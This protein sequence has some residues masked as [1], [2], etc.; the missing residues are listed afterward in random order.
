MHP[1][2]QCRSRY[3]MLNHQWAHQSPSF[4]TDRLPAQHQLSGSPCILALRKKKQHEE[5]E[6]EHIRGL[7]PPCSTWPMLTTKIYNLF[8][9]KKTKNTVEAMNTIIS[10]KC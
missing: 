7:H 8:F 10:I 1:L 4:P 3:H 6:L 2:P 5:N 9:K